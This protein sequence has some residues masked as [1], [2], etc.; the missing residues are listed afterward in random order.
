MLYNSERSSEKM[1]AEEVDESKM[2][3]AD[4]DRMEGDIT[5]PYKTLT[6]R[7]AI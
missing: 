7:L 4:K 5:K 6:K 2:L 1:L 3:L